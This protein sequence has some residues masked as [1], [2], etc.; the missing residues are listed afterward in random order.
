MMSLVVAWLVSSE[1]TPP[2]AS[3]VP[4]FLRTKN[5]NTLLYECLWK[6]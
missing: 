6:S 5:A 4:R 2:G 3:T 1:L